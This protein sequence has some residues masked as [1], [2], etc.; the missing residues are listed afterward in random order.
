MRPSYQQKY[1]MQFRR[2]TKLASAVL[3]TTVRQFPKSS[4]A[5]WCALTVK[6]L[7]SPRHILS[8]ER[9]VVR[10]VTFLIIAVSTYALAKVL[11]HGTLFRS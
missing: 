5:S 2:S 11:A 3:Q 1:G 10:Y 7:W 6:R 9:T 4:H 8:G